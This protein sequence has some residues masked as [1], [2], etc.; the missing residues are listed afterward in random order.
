MFVLIPF[1]SRRRT[2]VR[3]ITEGEFFCLYCNADRHYQ[4]RVWAEI[5]F[6]YLAQRKTSGEFVICDACGNT[7]DP[8]CLDESS[9]AEFEEL[10]VEPPHRAVLYE[11]LE[12]RRGN[13]GH[14]DDDDLLPGGRK[15][16]L[17][18]YLDS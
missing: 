14:R 10:L 6:Y 8:Q 13:G 1:V 12:R 17:S 15:M 5:R 9:T 16:T 2:Q 18:E 7:Y 4:H 11:K 3:L